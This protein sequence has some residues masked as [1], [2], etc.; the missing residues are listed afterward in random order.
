MIG[1]RLD[2]SVSQFCTVVAK[3]APQNTSVEVPVPDDS[4]EQ[5]VVRWVRQLASPEHALLERLDEVLVLFVVQRVEVREPC[6][7]QGPCEEQHVGALALSFLLQVVGPKHTMDWQ[8]NVALPFQ[9]SPLR[10][11]S[12]LL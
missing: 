4:L 1:L 3:V 10:S 7:A 2:L 9:W 11:V 5:R 8:P 12:F 6:E